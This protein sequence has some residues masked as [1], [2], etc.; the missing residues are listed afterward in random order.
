MNN[1]ILDYLI[2]TFLN[3]NPIFGGKLIA[4]AYLSLANL[5]PFLSILVIVLT[6]IVFCSIS[7]HFANYFRKLKIFS[8]KLSNIDEKWVKSGA[9]VGFFVGQLFVGELFIALM[10]GLVEDKKN[11]VV[12][13]YIPM[14]VSTLLYTLV[15][16]YLTLHG[17]NV[18][19]DYA[20]LTK[21]VN[22]YKQFLK[23]I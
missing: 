22:I 23:Y 10:F 16:Y 13:F 6:E 4:V 3:I 19:K 20:V 1:S 11:I 9:Y 8:K 21:Q 12:Y 7:F 18:I 14:V 2:L 15:Y 5:N 17:V